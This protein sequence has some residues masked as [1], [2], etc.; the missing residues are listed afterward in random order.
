MIARLQAL[1]RA[2][3]R[4]RLELAYRPVI[5]NIV[6]LW[7]D[8]TAEAEWPVDPA[9]RAVRLLEDAGV[10]VSGAR[11]AVNYLQVLRPERDAAQGATPAP[12]AP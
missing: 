11:F 5:E 3:T 10:F 8:W 12:P 7:G 4:E 2:F 6:R 9:L 1:E